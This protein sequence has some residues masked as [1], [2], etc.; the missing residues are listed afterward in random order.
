MIDLRTIRTGRTYGA[1]YRGYG[2]VPLRFGGN[3]VRRMGTQ[4]R[5]YSG[6][7]RYHSLYLYSGHNTENA[8]HFFFKCENYRMARL[9]LFRET[10]EFYPLRLEYIL[11]GK[12]SFSKSSYF[13]LFQ[14]VHRY[15]KESKRF[16]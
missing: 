2:Y 10:R 15:I 7:F 16:S 14:A 1:P 11:Y 4:Q 9:C 3:V 8:S 13:L 6:T 12:P 5:A